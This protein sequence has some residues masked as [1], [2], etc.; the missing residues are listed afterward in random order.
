VAVG[1][2]YLPPIVAPDRLA[3]TTLAR[4]RELERRDLSRSVV[5]YL[6]DLR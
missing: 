3:P 1:S 5:I 4:W 2:E 6:V